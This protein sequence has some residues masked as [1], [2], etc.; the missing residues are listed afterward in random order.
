MHFGCYPSGFALTC[1]PANN[2]SEECGNGEPA[3]RRIQLLRQMVLNRAAKQTTD[4]TLIAG[5]GT[6]WAKR[7][8]NGGITNLLDLATN[9]ASRLQEL[10]GLSEKR[11]PGPGRLSE[12]SAGSLAA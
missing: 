7:L 8:V 3:N 11:A 2:P 4:L 6:K 9:G 10:D 1:Q 5:I 12:E